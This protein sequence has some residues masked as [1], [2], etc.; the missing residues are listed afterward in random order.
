MFLFVATTS[1]NSKRMQAACRSL[2]LI[3]LADYL[4][5]DIRSRGALNC[6]NH[7]RVGSRRFPDRHS[8]DVSRTWNMTMKSLKREALGRRSIHNAFLREPRIVD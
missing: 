8:K 7:M 1:G 4:R 3:V 5:R 2:G 6:V